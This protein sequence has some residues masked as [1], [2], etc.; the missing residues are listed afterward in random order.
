MFEKHNH[1]YYLFHDGGPYHIEN[2]RWIWRANQRAGFY[3]IGT[4]V[5]KEL[6]ILFT[7]FGLRFKMQVRTKVV[8]HDSSQN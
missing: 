7:R 4:S 5:M 1:Y 3:M 8:S 6:K 2:S